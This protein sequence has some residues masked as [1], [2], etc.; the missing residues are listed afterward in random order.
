MGETKLMGKYVE[1]P[2]PIVPTAKAGQV[3]VV[4]VSRLNFKLKVR[5]CPTLIKCQLEHGLTLLLIVHHKLATGYNNFGYTT[6]GI[7]LGFLIARSL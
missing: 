1:H 7:S 2:S 4:E 6:E 5:L 3:G